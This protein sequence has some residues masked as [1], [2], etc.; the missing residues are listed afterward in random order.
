ML[1]AKI[2]AVESGPVPLASGEGRERDNACMALHAQ[3]VISVLPLCPKA[4]PRR[5]H[6]PVSSSVLR[7][8]FLFLCFVLFLCRRKPRANSHTVNTRS[9]GLASPP[10][11]HFTALLDGHPIGGIVVFRTARSKLSEINVSKS[12]SSKRGVPSPK[13]PW[14]GRPATKSRSRPCPLYCQS[15]VNP[16]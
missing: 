5:L 16:K 11:R 14:P 8:L 4:A 15:H 2:W 6:T 9:Y 7:G 10:V 1:E 12:S 13:A 3:H